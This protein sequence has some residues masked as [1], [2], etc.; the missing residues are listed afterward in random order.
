MLRGVGAWRPWTETVATRTLHPFPARMAPEI[1]I[2][3]LTS[4]TTQRGSVLLDPMCGSG[5]VLVAAAA[6]GHIAIGTDL[7]PLAVLISSVSTQPVD[8]DAL[9]S[10]ADHA[11]AN[12]RSDTSRASRWSDD[13]TDRFA[14]YWFGKPQRLAL[15]RLSRQLDSV[16][17]PTIRG[18]LRLAMSRQIVTKVPQASLAADTSH[19]RP[20]RVITDSAYDVYAGF[21]ASVKALSA[22]LARRSHVGNVQVFEGDARHIALPDGSVDLVVTSP[23]YLNAIDYMRGH[24]LALIWMGYTIPQ[25]RVLRSTSVGSER[26]IDVAPPAAA[27]LAAE[28]G[29]AE[30]HDEKVLPTGTILRYATDLYQFASDSYRVCRTGARLVAVVGNS[31]LRGNYIR[32]D[33]ILASCLSSAGF[34]LTTRASRDLPE[35]RRYLPVG[36]LHSSALGKRMRREVILTAIKR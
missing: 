32:N 10:A 27:T 13:E 2:Q 1:A 25:L 23:P 24:R 4:P 6:A 8:L 9:R 29:W 15:T 36:S 30:A 3:E 12:A 20:H 21:A 7:D 19:S 31:T 22:A 16:P 28:L 33:E 14:H 5:T 11:I 17:N 26:G 34:T 18:A 35:S